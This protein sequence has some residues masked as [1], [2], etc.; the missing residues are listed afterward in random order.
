MNTREMASQYRLS[1]W[2]QSLQ[3][4]V[5]RKESIRE[6]CKRKGISK[7]TYYYWQRKIR[8]KVV[9][10]VQPITKEPTK[11]VKTE[12]TMPVPAGW[13]QIEAIAEARKPEETEVTIEIGKCRISANETTNAELLTKVCKLL[14]E[15]C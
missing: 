12:T 10:Q 11:S 13:M 3:E 7:N 1:S 4:R 9:E 2:S 14:V 5:T 15:L 6:F 8:E